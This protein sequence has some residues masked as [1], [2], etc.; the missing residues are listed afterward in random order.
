MATTNLMRCPVCLEEFSYD[1]RIYCELSHQN[2][3]DLLVDITVTHGFALYDSFEETSLVDKQ[4]RT[5]QGLIYA[6]YRFQG[7]RYVR[8]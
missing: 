4:Y 3:G 1:T 2:Y 5:V 6:F 8:C 7:N